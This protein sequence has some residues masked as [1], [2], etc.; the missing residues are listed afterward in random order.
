MAV[1]SAIKVFN[2]TAT[3]YKGSIAFEPPIGLLVLAVL[4]LLFPLTLKKPIERW[5]FDE[6]AVPGNGEPDRDGESAGDR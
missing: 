3:L 2:W 1:P 5:L 4:Y 6:A